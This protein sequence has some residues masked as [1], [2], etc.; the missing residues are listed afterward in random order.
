MQSYFALLGGKKRDKNSAATI[1][2]TPTLILL[3]AFLSGIRI[4]L[5]VRRIERILQKH[6]QA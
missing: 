6:Q 4:S 2:L 5:S 1:R 3:L